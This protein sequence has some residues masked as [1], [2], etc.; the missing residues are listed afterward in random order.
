MASEQFPI[1]KGPTK[2]DLMTAF[3]DG[4][5]SKKGGGKEARAITF[6]GEDGD[7]APRFSATISSIRLE[8]DSYES[9]YMTGYV[10]QTS[11]MKDGKNVPIKANLRKPREA[12][13]HLTTNTRKGY[14]KFLD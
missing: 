2:F 9:W 11:E 12:E 8:G 3:F 7:D 6:R 5:P 13:F 14:V 1:I 10:T 4:G